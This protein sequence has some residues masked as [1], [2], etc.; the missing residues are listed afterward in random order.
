MPEIEATKDLILTSGEMQ[1]NRWYHEQE[2]LRRFSAFALVGPNGQVTAAEGAVST[3]Y[4]NAYGIRIVLDGFP[5]ALPK[6]LPR[7]WALHPEVPHRY[8]DGSL[9]IMRSD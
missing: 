8:A 4:E 9:C 7:G 6:V 3:Q 2:R 1:A 5:N